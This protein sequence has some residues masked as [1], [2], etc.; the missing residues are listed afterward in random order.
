MQ[1]RR[2]LPVLWVCMV[3]QKELGLEGWTWSSAGAGILGD[4]KGWDGQHRDMMPVGHLEATQLSMTLW[5]V[6]KPVVRPWAAELG[7]T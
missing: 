1:Q 3:L 7:P 6:S 4:L 5:W 2:A